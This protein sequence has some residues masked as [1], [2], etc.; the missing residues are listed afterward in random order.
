M[1]INYHTKKLENAFQIHDGPIQSISVNEAFC[2]TGSEDH[3]L[4]VWLLDFSEYFIEAPHEGTVS[5][6]DISP[7]G[8]QIV[9]GTANGSL[10]MVDIAKEKYV[11]LLRSHSDE[12]I[13]ADYNLKR[14]Y[15]ITVSK[16]KT[17]RLWGVEGDFQRIYEFVSPNDQAISVSSHPSLPLF[18]CGF[19]SGTLRIFDIERTKVC[20]V[21]SQFN[22]PLEEL[23]YSSDSRLLITASKDGYLAIHNV[24]LQH[25]PIKMIPV[26][27]A[28]PHVSVAFDPTNSAFGAFGDNG[29]YVNIYNSVNFTLMN[30]VNIKKDVGKCFVFSPTEFHLIVATIS[31]KIKVY[32]LKTEGGSTP[33]R[34]ITNVHRDSINSIN[35]SLNGQYFLT[36]GNDKTVKV[37]NADFEKTDFYSFQSF[38]GHTFPVKRAFFNPNNN[39]QCIS[40]GGKDGIHLWKFFGDSAA[41]YDSYSPELQALN[42]KTK[43]MLSYKGPN[44]EEVKESE[45]E[46]SLPE[47]EEL[48]VEKEQEQNKE[49]TDM[50]NLDN[51]SN[52]DLKILK[53]SDSKQDYNDYKETDLLQDGSDYEHGGQESIQEV[54]NEE[55]EEV[56][57]FDYNGTNAQDNVVWIQDKHVVIFT[58]GND[59]IAQRDDGS[60][61]VFKDGHASDVSALAVSYDNNLL[62]SCSATIDGEGTAP[63]ILWN[64]DDN[65]SKKY[66]LRS[67]EIG[68]K[69]LL[70]SKDGEFLISQSCNEERSLVVWD[71]EDGLVVKSTICPIPYSGITL[72]E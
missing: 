50:S 67:H 41:N 8:T 2:V 53:D 61:Y 17:I 5:A 64:L 56:H 72:L 34:E 27:F 45:P 39:N 3:L 59:I 31:C 26:D 40:I 68:V 6:V 33:L 49:N 54:E 16:D 25:Q 18:A 52:Q 66:E 19:E 14:N 22:L 44:K 47:T 43:M 70:F 37:F 38:I 9:C 23:V 10:G 51:E 13:A 71:V 12:I 21:Y 35:F 29:N 58:S 42:E 69:T 28:P 4:R 46:E 24:K 30:T 15:I 57:E 63:I 60:Q 32:D 62:A 48:I 11:T 20:E 36:C 1:I 7:D 55:T 65:Y